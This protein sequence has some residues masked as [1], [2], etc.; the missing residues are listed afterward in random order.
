MDRS[1]VAKYFQSR[2]NRGWRISMVSP[3]ICGTSKE[4]PTVAV[5]H[6]DRKEICP[7]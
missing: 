4:T 5:V 6:P 2:N 3:R 7:G 1:T